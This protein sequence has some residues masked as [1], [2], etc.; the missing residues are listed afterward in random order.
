[1]SEYYALS[2]ISCSSKAM[3]IIRPNPSSQK[4]IRLVI[5]R[6]GIPSAIPILL[7]SP[8]VE[9]A[10]LRHVATGAKVII[11]S[12]VHHMVR[13]P[14]ICHMQYHIHCLSVDT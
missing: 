9:A 3:M 7:G 12:T 11:I 5:I 2:P 6:V 1:M 4:T 10:Y 13:G 14:C 8:I